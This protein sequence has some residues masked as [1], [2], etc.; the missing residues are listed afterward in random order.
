MLTCNATPAP[1][2]FGADMLAVIAC[3]VLTVLL[4]IPLFAELFG[5]HTM[6][7]A[8]AQLALASVV[9]FVFGARFYKAAYKTVR[10]K[11]GTWICSSPWGPLQLTVSACTSSSLIPGK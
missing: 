5:A 2:R 3:A 10:A 8:S 11:A 7:P 6:L 1:S 4:V 9:Q